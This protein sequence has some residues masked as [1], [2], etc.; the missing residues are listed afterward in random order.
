MKILIEVETSGNGKTYELILDDK[1]TVRAAREK[2]IEEI[3]S[4]E[5]DRIGFAES[6]ALY[7][8]DLRARLPDGR[9]LRKA[10]LVSGQKLLLL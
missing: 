2:I 8:K 6:A 10:G 3:I 7:V 5:N 4:F 1:L 9:N